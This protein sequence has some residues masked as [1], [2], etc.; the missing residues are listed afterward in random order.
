MLVR[1]QSNL[2]EES[3]RAPEDAARRLAAVR[4][5]PPRRRSVVGS[6]FIW[7]GLIAQ[8]ICIVVLIAARGMSPEGK[9]YLGL[10]ALWLALYA[11]V[12]IVPGTFVALVRTIGEAARLI[13]NDEPAVPRLVFYAVTT[14]MPL[15]L[16]AI[17]LWV[18]P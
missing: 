12:V 3:S 16:Y 13:R 11:G 18:Y 4:P 9:G 1:M 2:D 14:L 15:I 5:N 8:L 17:V 6:L 7:L 10:A